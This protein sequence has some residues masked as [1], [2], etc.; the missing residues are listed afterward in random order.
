M[1]EQTDLSVEQRAPNIRNQFSK[2]ALAYAKYRRDYPDQ[3]YDLVYKFCENKNA[4]VLDVGCGTGLVTRHLTEYYRDVTGTDKESEMI[5]LAQ[6]NNTALSFIVAKT[7]ELPFSDA[8][9]DLITVASA[10]HWFNYDLAGKEIHRI[11]KPDGKLCVFWKYDRGVSRSYL[12][13]FAWKN[14][15]KFVTDVQPTIK[16]QINKK[17]FTDVGFKKVNNKEFDFQETYTREEILGY[18]QSH[19]TFNLLDDTQKEQYLALNEKVVDEHLINGNFIFESRMTM[20]F[21]EK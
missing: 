10:Y 20:Y 21:I 1:K 18:I 13:N 12:P 4:K 8:N 7:E 2:V 5:A 14:L 3:V 11:L 9:F 17:V 15:E 19:S 16:K 6:K